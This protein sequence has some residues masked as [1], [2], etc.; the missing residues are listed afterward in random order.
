MLFRIIYLCIHI[1]SHQQLAFFSQGSKHIYKKSKATAFPKYYYLIERS[2]AISNQWSAVSSQRSAVGD[3]QSV[4]SS[5]QSAVS[6]Q[7][8]LMLITAPCVA[9]ICHTHVIQYYYICSN[10]RSCRSI[11]SY[12]YCAAFLCDIAL[13]SSPNEMISSAVN[14]SNIL[15]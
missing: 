10:I 8:L 3:Q 5:Q 1:L 9:V 12:H 2:I 6:G 11:R 14:S 13:E 7:Q 4:I 15:S